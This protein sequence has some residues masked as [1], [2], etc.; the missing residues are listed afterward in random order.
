MLEN[1]VTEVICYCN[2]SWAS[3]SIL[4]T[5]LSYS[6]LNRLS[7]LN[8]LQVLAKNIVTHKEINLVQLLFDNLYFSKILFNLQ[9]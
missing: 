9:F 2:Q 4:V 5:V 8:K 1:N 7:N 3:Y 6:Y